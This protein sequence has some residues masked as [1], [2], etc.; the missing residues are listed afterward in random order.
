MEG[1]AEPGHHSLDFTKLPLACDREL[2]RRG[3][4]VEEF[5]I[6][7]EHVLFKWE[8]LCGAKEQLG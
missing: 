4:S 3:L 8:A 2:V 5:R 7:R 1:K 6:L